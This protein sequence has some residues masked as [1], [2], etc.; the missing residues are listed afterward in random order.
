MPATRLARATILLAAASSAALLVGCAALPDAQPLSRPAPTV[1]AAG[2][3]LASRT[4]L[5]EC[6]PDE[7]VQRPD[8]YTLSCGDGNEWLEGLVWV[9]WGDPTASATGTLVTNSCEPNC[10]EGTLERRSVT[11]SVTDLAQGEGA[12]NYRTLRVDGG[13]NGAEQYDL[14]GVTTGE[15]DWMADEPPSSPT[16]EATPSA[17]PT[18]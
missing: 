16:P 3:A 15:S 12:A 7:L 13:P 8:R 1:D 14:P 18:R 6:V 4:Y 10:A 2:E 17:Q 11:V 5:V 9:D